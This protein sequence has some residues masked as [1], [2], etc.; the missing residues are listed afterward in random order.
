MNETKTGSSWMDQ[1]RKEQRKREGK[2]GVVGL[3]LKK[4]Y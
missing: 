4:L 3:R 2:D 1:W